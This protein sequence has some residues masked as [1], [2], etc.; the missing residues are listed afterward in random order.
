MLHSA[1]VPL[2]PCPLSGCQNAAEVRAVSR[3]DD[4]RLQP[5]FHHSRDRTE[6][7]GRPGDSQENDQDGKGLPTSTHM[8]YL[9]SENRNQSK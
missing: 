2:S 6:P 5:V 8:F 4:R 1:G 7:P 9:K 3:E